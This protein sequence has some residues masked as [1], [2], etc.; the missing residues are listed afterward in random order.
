GRTLKEKS[1]AAM[2]V[3]QELAAELQR[4]PTISELAQK[5]GVEITEA[6]Q[7]ITVS[8]PT[9]S[10]TSNDDEG[11]THQLDIPVH[12]PEE[13]I[14]DRIALYDLIKN[15]DE[16]DRKLIEFRYF[17]GMTQA[18]TAD[19]LNMSQVQVSRREKMILLKMRESL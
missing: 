2:K 18:K 5:L 15:L 19:R 16:R 4:E 7:L 9:I 10:L 8:M 14:S 1:R 17:K 6:A 12:S 3:K 11:D 13:E